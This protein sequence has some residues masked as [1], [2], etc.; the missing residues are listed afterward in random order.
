MLAFLLPLVLASAVRAQVARPD[1]TAADSVSTLTGDW[2]RDGGR[3]GFD[4]L[5]VRSVR[6]VAAWA[7][8]VRRDLATGALT[9]RSRA[10]ALSGTL[11][12]EPRFVVDGL[13]QVDGPFVPF[14]SVERVRVLTEGVPARYG[15]A[16]GGLVLVETEAEADALGG[17]VEAYSSRATDAYGADLGALAV[18]GPLGARGGFSVSA[19]I[20]RQDDATPYGADYFSLTDEAY[21]LVQRSPQAVSVIEGGVERYVPFPAEAARAAFDAGRPFTTDD[22][23]AALG[24]GADALIETNPVSIVS[25]LGP[26]AFERRAAKDAP[27]DD[28]RLAGASVLRPASGLR[29]R[30]SGRLDRQRAERTGDPLTVYRSLPFARDAVYGAESDGHALV[31]ELSHDVSPA[32]GYRLSAGR[33]AST[34]VRYPFG[35]SSDVRDALGYGDIDSEAA[36]VARLYVQPGDGDAFQPVNNRDAF[37]FPTDVWFASPGRRLG[38]YRRTHD[39][40]LQA[41]GA[42][43]ARLGPGRVEV[44]ADVERETHRLFLLDGFPLAQ[45][46]ADGTDVRQVGGIPEAGVTRYEQLPYFALRPRARYYGYTFDGLAETDGGIAADI[47][48][49]TNGVPVSSDLP[50]FRPVTAAA[51]AQGD[52]EVG[53]V[54]LS[55]GVRVERY[56]ANAETLIDPLANQPIFRA[57]SLASVPSGIGNDYGVYYGFGVREPQN[58]VGFRDLEGNQYDVD[59]QRVSNVD[60]IALAGQHVVDSSQPTGAAFGPSP[61][62]TSLQPRLAVRV[63]ASET[64]RLSASYDR[65]TRNPPPELHATIPEYAS[66][67]AAARL[68]NPDLRPETVEAFRLGA[69]GAM[70]PDLDVSAAFFHRRTEGQI[71]PRNADGGLTPYTL[72]VNGGATRATGGDLSLAWHPSAAL[73]VSASYTLSFAEATFADPLTLGELAGP[74]G[75]FAPA[76]D[77][78]RHALDVVGAYRLPSSWGPVLRGLGAGLSFSAQSGLPYTPL[79]RSPQFIVFDSFTAGAR[80]PLNSARLPW[81]SQLNLRLDK[82]VRVAG[83]AVEAFVWVENLLDADNVLAVYRATGTPDTDGFFSAVPQRRDSFPPGVTELYDEYVSGPVNVGDNQSTSA[84]YFYGRPRQI[85]LGLRATL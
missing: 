74:P 31:G 82:Q 32:I 69:D 41:R 30:L 10:G 15:Q 24:L 2:R 77:D 35:F 51:Y 63:V 12:Q 42:V 67:S 80:G 46:F 4:A 79:E 20:G 37:F 64:V 1:S 19:E 65:L 62:H 70:T 73:G 57:G 83:A 53:P 76:P 40:S 9:V 78:T 68:P 5:P 22:L 6:E 27:L 60:I 14:E 84:P 43:H 8:G 28:L 52:V 26:E 11:G 38:E 29:L 45:F 81:T 58:V 3:L 17:R 85:R 34:S 50:P 55:L 75:G 44:G 49:V 72:Y 54:A 23:R 7:P 16:A 36:R 59:G 21:A 18:R 61:T 56:S 48:E 13:R 47:L 39:A 25:A 33:V 71:V 66:A